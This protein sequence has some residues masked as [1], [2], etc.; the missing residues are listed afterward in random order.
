MEAC[1]I[2]EQA[3]SNAPASVWC[4]VGSGR[5]GTQQCI[6]E[7]ERCVGCEGACRIDEQGRSN[8]PASVSGD[9]PGGPRGHR[10]PTVLVRVSFF[11]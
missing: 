4:V 2:D 1:R 11:R 3:R 9:A 10:V 6:R 8:A 7:C 5:A